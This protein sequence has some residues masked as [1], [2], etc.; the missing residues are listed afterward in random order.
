MVIGQ[1]DGQFAAG[2]DDMTSSCASTYTGRKRGSYDRD[3]SMTTR[4]V[5]D[6]VESL[7]YTS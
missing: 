7:T 1:L 3:V 4:C 2:N 6:G 5:I